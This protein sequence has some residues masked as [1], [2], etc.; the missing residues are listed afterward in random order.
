MK[1]KFISQTSKFKSPLTENAQNPIS[2]NSSKTISPNPWSMM[3]N[4]NVSFTMVI[5]W[6]SFF[7]FFSVLP[8]HLWI[9]R[10]F[11]PKWF[12]LRLL[13]SSYFLR[14]NRPIKPIS[15]RTS[16]VQIHYYPRNWQHGKCSYLDHLWYAKSMPMHETH[17]QE[18]SLCCK[19][20]LLFVVF[21]IFLSKISQKKSCRFTAMKCSWENS[22]IIEIDDKNWFLFIDTFEES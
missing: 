8:Y 10:R 12:P 13:I 11:P 9:S 5:W 19:K 14:R 22:F 18:L 7:V 4:V 3:P 2:K 17:K 15:L 16:H 20:L 6:I 1:E 21:C